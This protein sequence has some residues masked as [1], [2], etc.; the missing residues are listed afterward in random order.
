MKAFSVSKARVLETPEDEEAD[1]HLAEAQHNIS[2]KH[3]RPF[4]AT[5][6]GRSRRWIVFAPRKIVS[7]DNAKL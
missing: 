4:V 6:S 3:G 5:A 2:V 1:E 7:W